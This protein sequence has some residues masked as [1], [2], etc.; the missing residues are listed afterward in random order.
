M[1]A[2]H[3]MDGS[4]RASMHN[5]SS[6]RLENR[7][8]PRGRIMFAPTILSSV[9]A[10]ASGG[11]RLMGASLRRGLAVKPHSS[12]GNRRG[13]VQQSFTPQVAPQARW[14]RAAHGRDILPD[15]LGLLG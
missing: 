1:N 12:G 2:L 13:W 15:M 11:I 3:R 10:S 6:E 7:L 4:G 14:D 9:P 5:R 8:D